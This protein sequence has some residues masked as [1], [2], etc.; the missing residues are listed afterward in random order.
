MA[1]FYDF[2]YIHLLLILKVCESKIVQDKQVGFGD[3]LQELV[4]T[5]IYACHFGFN[6]QLLQVII[7]HFVALNAS[8]MS[9]GRS[10]EAF[11]T[12]GGAGNEYGLSLIDVFSCSQLGD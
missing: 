8:V 12:A 6:K 2:H 1:I 9:Q 3:L 4:D 11:P 5:A 10:Q 7:S